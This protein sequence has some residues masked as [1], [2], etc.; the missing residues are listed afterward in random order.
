MT[1][2]GKLGFVTIICGALGVFE[3]Q[4]GAQEFYEPDNGLNQTVETRAAVRLKMPFGKYSNKPEDNGL[5]LSLNFG[6]DR[7]A[8]W[9][10]PR[11]YDSYDNLFELGLNF[12][13]DHYANLAGVPYGQLRDDRLEISGDGAVALWLVGGLAL[14]AGSVAL[15]VLAID[16]GIDE[17]QEL[18]EN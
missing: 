10:S 8:N 1:Y 12:K 7:R 13:G 6:V 9:R 5:Q 15:A 18:T 11:A 17:I 4:A 16:S 2:L 3:G 14:T